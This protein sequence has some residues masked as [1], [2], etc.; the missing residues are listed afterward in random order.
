MSDDFTEALERAYEKAL[1]KMEGLISQ[2]WAG[3]YNSLAMPLSE[4]H[5][6]A[7]CLVRRLKHF[8]K[9]AYERDPSCIQA[10]LESLA[11]FRS[12]AQRMDD[13]A[14]E[15]EW[16]VWDESKYTSEKEKQEGV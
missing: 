8:N 5:I 6:T 14:R 7:C 13:A 1:P 11:L 2:Q 3:E 10:A 16:H 15:L 9:L 12:M 4:A